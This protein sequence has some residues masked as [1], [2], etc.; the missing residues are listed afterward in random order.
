MITNAH[1]GA[2][3][4]SIGAEKR[5]NAGLRTAGFVLVGTYRRYPVGG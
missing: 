2:T 5:K 1:S 3:V 4:A